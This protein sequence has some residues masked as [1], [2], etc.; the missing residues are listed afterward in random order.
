MRRQREKEK[1]KEREI[2]RLIDVAKY[3]RD[4]SIHIER[5]CSCA[6]TYVN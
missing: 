4:R 2:Y 5:A 6:S 1:E 3:H